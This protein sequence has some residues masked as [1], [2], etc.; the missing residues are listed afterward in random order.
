[1][2]EDAVPVL[3][4]ADPATVGQADADVPDRPVGLR[5]AQAA[6]V[7]YT[8]GSTGTPKGVV[9]S[10]AGLASLAAA[11]IEHFAVDGNSRVLRYAASPSFDASVAEIAVELL[12]GATLVLADGEDVVPRDITH[13][14]LR[15]RCWRVAPDGSATT[16][17]SWSRRGLAAELVERCRWAGGC[18]TRTGRRSRGGA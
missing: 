14:T 3:T 2:L 12:A 5:P 10:H 1:M 4:V 7:I 15:R 9:V 18:S 17:C 13:V 8:S 11:Q 16:S 6:Y